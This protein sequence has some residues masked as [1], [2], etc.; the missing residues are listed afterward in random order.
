MTNE[1]NI[2][3]MNH[4]ELCDYIVSVYTTGIMVGKNKIKLSE[5][6]FVDYDKWLKEEKE[7]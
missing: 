4:Q 7:G 6:A 3:N 5:T 1:E 2:R